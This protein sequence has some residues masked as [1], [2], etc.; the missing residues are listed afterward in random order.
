MSVIATLLTE[1]VHVQRLRIAVRDRHDLRECADWPELTRV[2]ERE[3]VRVA[4]VDLHAGGSPDFE[5]VRAIK[6]RQPRLALVAYVTMMPERGHDLFDAGRAGVDS[7]V[8][9]GVDDGPRPLLAAVERAEARSL[10]GHIRRALEGL[11]PFVVDALLLAVTRAHE[12][13]TPAVLCKL[14]ALPRRAA[15]E[16]LIE[17][18]FPPPQRLLT[19]GRLIV[20]AHMLED[21]HRSAER[22][23]NALDFPSGSA[24]RNV[25]QR[26]LRATPREIRARGGAEYVLRAL[27]R[28]VRPS[29][30]PSVPGTRSPARVPTIAL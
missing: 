20:A 18:G 6:H 17:H 24:F 27:L 3:A 15:T 5:A 25:C 7:L 22:V 9:A 14:L 30:A 4:V 16:R 13:L 2:C 28:R 1:T 11:D 29:P 10:T 8:L 26:H 21:S 12:R 23:A 19:W